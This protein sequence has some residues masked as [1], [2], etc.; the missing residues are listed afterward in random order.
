MEGLCKLL[1]KVYDMSPREACNYAKEKTFEG[2]QATFEAQGGYKISQ[3]EELEL[4]NDYRKTFPLPAPGEKVIVFQCNSLSR[5]LIESSIWEGKMMINFLVDMA[6]MVLDP[7][8]KFG[9]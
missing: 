2:A 9:D 7:R 4:V 8:I 1:Q 6:Y 3:I 5:V